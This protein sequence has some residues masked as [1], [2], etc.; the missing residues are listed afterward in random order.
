MSYIP[1][2]IQLGTVHLKSNYESLQSQ[3]PLSVKESVIQLYA[4]L[5][6]SVNKCA[7]R[8]NKYINSFLISDPFL[9][10]VKLHPYLQSFDNVC[11]GSKCAGKCLIEIIGSWGNFNMLT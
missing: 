8:K 10:P 2:H 11:T 6:L 3:H 5:S 9:A 1:S 7:V 4:I